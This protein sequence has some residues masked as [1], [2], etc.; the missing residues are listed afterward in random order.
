MARCLVLDV[1]GDKGL[2]EK[3]CN[4]LQDFYDALRCDCFD[5][6]TRR[7]DGTYFD[8]F[9]DDVGLFADNPIP[10]VIDKNMKP[11]LV[12]NV[13]FANHDMEGNTTSLSDDDISHIKENMI[14]AGDIETG[15]SWSVV[16]ADY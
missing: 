5:I 8:M 16:I 12:G 1:I 7:V 9:V 4:E 10:S 15:R 11:M 6:A 14:Y 2:Y 3:E 13:V